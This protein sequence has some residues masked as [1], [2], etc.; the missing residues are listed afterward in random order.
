MLKGRGVRLRWGGPA[1]GSPSR[2]TGI[3]WWLKFGLTGKHLSADEVF[4]DMAVSGLLAASTSTLAILQAPT[5]WAQMLMLSQFVAS[6]VAV[7]YHGVNAYRLESAG[8]HLGRIGGA[9]I[10][11]TPYV[12]G[13]LVLLESHGLLQTLGG[14]LTAWTLA[15]RPEALE[16]IGRVFVVF[17]FNEIVA[18]ALGLA[19]KGMPL[20]SV[21]SR[22]PLLAVAVG[23]VAAPWV[24]AY[25]SGETVAS[26]PVVVRWFATV[27]TTVLSQGRALGG[28][29][30]GHRPG[31][32]CHQRPDADPGDGPGAPGSRYEEGDG[33]QR[34]LHGDL[35]RDR[36]ALG[37]SRGPRVRG[38]V[39][40]ARGDGLRGA[41]LPD[42][43][44]DHRDL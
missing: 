29:L 26:W 42:G 44:D 28:G 39:S 20:R 10:V 30:S 38:R 43:Q 6:V 1:S 24:A 9:L 31:H 17:C 41:G 21:R 14:A 33:L 12:V 2:G 7:L 40:G 13:G 37:G 32:G 11:G 19:T 35:A 4:Q 5:A 23:V 34:R 22:L 18:D 36:S 25:G 3:A 16:F 15:S 27:L 8:K